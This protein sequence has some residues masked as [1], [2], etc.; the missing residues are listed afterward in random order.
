[1][2]WGGIKDCKVE[3]L[4][5]S[6]KS[7]RNLLLGCKSFIVFSSQERIHH[8]WRCKPGHDS[9]GSGGHRP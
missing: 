2:S 1:M 3:V 8:T 9:H 6:I 5:Q 4:L 7:M